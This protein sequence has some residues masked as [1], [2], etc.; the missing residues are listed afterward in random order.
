MCSVHLFSVFGEI[1]AGN[2]TVLAIFWFVILSSADTLT[3][4]D[5][6][7]DNVKKHVEIPNIV[8]KTENFATVLACMTHVCKSVGS[9]V[10]ISR[11][12]Y[13]PYTHKAIHPDLH[14]GPIP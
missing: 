14:R 2:F 9:F 7:K 11:H 13:P 4:G 6:K 10:S 5:R 3:R 1:S 12:I 8:E